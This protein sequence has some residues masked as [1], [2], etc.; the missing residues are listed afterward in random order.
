VEDVLTKSHS[1]Q[2]EDVDTLAGLCLLF[3]RDLLEQVGYMDEGFAFGNFEDDD[4]CLRARLLG[5]R[6][7]IVRDA[8]VHHHGMRTFKAMGLDYEEEFHLREEVFRRKWQDD[9]AG[10][11]HLAYRDHRMGEAAPLARSALGAH[12]AWPD[13]HLI[14][15]HHAANL[16]RSEEA[17]EHLRS[18]VARCPLHS[19]AVTLLAMQILRA[20]DADSGVRLLIWALENCHLHGEEAAKLL[21]RYGRWCLDRGR[22]IDALQALADACELDSECATLHNLLGIAQLRTGQTAEAVP[23]FQ[24][25]LE[26]GCSEAQTNLGICFWH[27]DKPAKAL[28]HFVEAVTVDPSDAAARS[29]LQGALEACRSLGLDTRGLSERLEQQRPLAGPSFQA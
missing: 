27:L 11:A 24:R 10:A 20:G 4:F 18:Y 5:H 6:L 23:R 12:P 8:F 26:L 9:P 2:I 13:A 3:H 14:L 29:N 1:G 21:L 17:I 19:Q 25:A 15:G 28:S 7:V 22:D 16:G